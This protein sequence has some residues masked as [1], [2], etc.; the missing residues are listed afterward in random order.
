MK[1]GVVTLTTLGL[2]GLSATALAQTPR[3][4]TGF[5]MD[6]RTGYSVPFGSAFNGMKLSDT[7]SG[8]VPILVDIG[9]KVIPQLFVGGY[10][11]FAIGG[12]GGDFEAGCNASN[13]DCL[14]LRFHLGVEA[15]YHILPA[16]R[17]NP[18]LGYGLGFESFGQSR[19]VGGVSTTRTLSGFEFARFMG[20]VDFRVHRVFG[21][22]PFVD[23]S[24]ASFSRVSNGSS[25]TSITDRATHEWL[26]IGARFVFFP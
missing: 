10:T 2:V 1:L 25:S 8:Q 22:G 19:T 7:S 13:A 9:A 3:A 18:W 12:A 17:V 11:G 6:I 26:T 21:V 20:G 23:L 24:M 16:G 14:T 4:R 5:Q 15:Q